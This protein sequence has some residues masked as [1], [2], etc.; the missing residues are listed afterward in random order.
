MHTMN[1]G[2]FVASLTLAG[3]TPALPPPASG[4]ELRHTE[5]V[6]AVLQVTRD[7]WRE[8]V[9]GALF[10]VDKIEQAYLARGV[11]RDALHFVAVFQGAAGY[12]VLNDRAFARFEGERAVRAQRNPNASPVRALVERG[13]RVELCASTMRRH[14][15]TEDDLLPEVVVVPNAYPRVI[16]LQ[17]DGYALLTF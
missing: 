13:V 8:D 7:E 12:H 4:T 6:R 1:A 17:M 3:C 11:E 9:S 2:L 14:G 10:Y 16:D 5:D 15:W